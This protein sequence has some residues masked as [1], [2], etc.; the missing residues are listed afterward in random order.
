V[1]KT[2]P[3]CGEVKAAREFGR[4]RSLPDGLSFYCLA[5][6]RE[7]N[8]RWYRDSRLRQGKQVRDLSWV[9]EGFRWC[10]ACRRA[11]PHGDYVRSSRTASGFGSRCKACHNATNKATYRQRRYGLTD[12]ELHALRVQQDDRCAICG[13]AGP[14]HLDHDHRTGLVRQWLC[15]RC[16]HGLG[17][18]RDDPAALRAA[19]GYVERHRT[20]ADSTVDA[21][22]SRPRR[23]S[24]PTGPGL[25]RRGA[26]CP[27]DDVVRAR[28][29]ALVAS[30]ERPPRTG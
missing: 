29:A 19:A 1:V 5:C 8:K 28:V 26:G 6:N 21:P 4:N 2:C 13:E 11:V 20:L 24:H 16:N 7:R 15:Q 27:S 18:F 9:P 10:P 12:A 23:R 22:R 3:E 17:L 30:L 25:R 14:E